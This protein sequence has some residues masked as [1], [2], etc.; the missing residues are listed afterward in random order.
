[1]ITVALALMAMSYGIG[2]IVFILSQAEAA[3]A[4]PQVKFLCRGD[5][6]WPDGTPVTWPPK[7]REAEV[8][9]TPTVR[10][11][12]TVVTKATTATAAQSNIILRDIIENLEPV[13]ICRGR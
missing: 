5:A 12:P 13:T 10:A 2:S 3:I 6:F 1:M 7:P 8:V 11:M 4:V 9:C